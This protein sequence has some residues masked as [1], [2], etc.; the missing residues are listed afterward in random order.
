MSIIKAEIQPNDW[1]T[2]VKWAWLILCGWRLSAVDG[3]AQLNHTQ[4]E[5]YFRGVTVAINHSKGNW[6]RTHCPL[7]IRES[8]PEPPNDA[9]ARSG[10][11]EDK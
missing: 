4:M 6:G 1:R 11:L 2:R 3:L 7:C 5:T 10:R 8:P 9:D